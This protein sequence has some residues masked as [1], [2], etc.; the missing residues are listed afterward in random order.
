MKSL[1]RFLRQL[2]VKFGRLHIA[3]VS[4]GG[5]YCLGDWHYIMLTTNK[6]RSEK[7]NITVDI[8][9]HAFHYYGGAWHYNG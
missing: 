1:V 5:M 6:G 2:A 7:A 3:Y 9:R 4:G 8:L